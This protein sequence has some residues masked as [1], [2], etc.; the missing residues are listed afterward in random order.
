MLKQAKISFCRLWRYQR[1]TSLMSSVASLLYAHA[2]Q[3][4]SFLMAM[5]DTPT[6]QQLAGVRD[7]WR[8]R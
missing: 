1:R 7:A 8:G 6:S 4:P 5:T 2:A 3:A